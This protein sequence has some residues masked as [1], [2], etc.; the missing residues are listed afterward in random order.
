M[1]F[2]I[3]I[4][5][6]VL[7]TCFAKAQ[8]NFA[9]VY[10]LIQKNIDSV[11]HGETITL[12]CDSAFIIEKKVF[13]WKA[14]GKWKRNND[15]VTFIIDTVHNRE[16]I[17]TQKSKWHFHLQNDD[18]VDATVLETERQYKKRNRKLSKQTQHPSVFEDYVVYKNRHENMI[19]K[20]IKSIT[21]KEE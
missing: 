11:L 13:K 7:N 1:R 16:H 18:L 8:N 5:V 2:F 17:I 3:T 14:T 10:H 9:G 12:T 4:I 6:L 15:R 21:C 19:Y 20:K